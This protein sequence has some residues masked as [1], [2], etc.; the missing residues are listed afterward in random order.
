MGKTWRQSSSNRPGEWAKGKWVGSGSFGKV[1]LAMNKA[2]GGLFVV[3][4][5]QSEAAP[6]SLRPKGANGE[7]QLN[8]FM[9]YMAGGSLFDIAEKFGGPLEETVVRLYT[10]EI[11]L[12]LKYLHQM[13]PFHCDLKSKNVLLDSSGNVKLA[14][15]GSA[16]RVNELGNNKSLI[17]TPLWTA[18]KVLR[19]EWLDFAVDIWSLGCT[20]IEMASGKPLWGDKVSN[21]VTVRGMDFLE[22]CLERDPKKRW[23]AEDLLN[24]PF[25][26]GS[27]YGSLRKEEK[28]FSPTSVLDIGM[29]EE[30]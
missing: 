29:W 13:E 21:P 5:A 26:L 18:P 4:S 10:K 8:L 23:K 11:L 28:V 22:K 1:H 6:C 25:I 2:T 9:E 27:S 7:N 30:G 15:F 24:H 12:G 20:V 3:K 14:D 19:N 17:G 16:R